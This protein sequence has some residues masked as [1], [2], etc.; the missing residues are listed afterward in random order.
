MALLK[1]LTLAAS[2]LLA[3][4]AQAAQAAQ[5]DTDPRTEPVNYWGLH[6]GVNTLDQL[7][8][9]VDFGAGT[10]F[11]GKADLNR[12]LH[13]GLM[14]GRQYEHSRYELEY[15]FG[16]FKVEHLTLGPVSQPA[17]GRGSYQALFANAY[18]TEQLADAIDAFAGAGI[19]WG[20]M[21][22]PRL[23]LG[24]TCNCFGPASK[25]GFAWQLRAGL[26]YHVSEKAAVALQYTWLNLP[27]L[28][29]DGP[30]AIAYDRKRFGALTLA[31][32][33]QF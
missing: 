16:R 19:G 28:D 11:E 27:R 13:G 31:Y 23:G 3:L 22:L 4:S 25:S 20:R 12:G 18:R 9:R 24:E 2:A 14:A 17:D 6:G 5:P 29:A 30:P 26:D 33:R 10:P 7:R 1:Q 15:E 21:K 32:S 8:A